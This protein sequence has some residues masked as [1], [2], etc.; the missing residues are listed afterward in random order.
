MNKPVT[1]LF[2][3]S[4][5]LLFAG[6]AKQ[7]A[8]DERPSYNPYV[9]S[10]TSG[11]VSRFSPVYLILSEDIPVD[12]LDPGTLADRLRIKPAAKGEFFFEDSHTLGFRPAGSLEQGTEYR[13]T[14]DLSHW[15]DADAKHARF[16][17]A[18]STYPLTLRVEGEALSEN[19]EEGYDLAYTLFTPD[20][21]TPE[22][23]EALVRASEDVSMEWQHQ[24]GERK[25]LLTLRRLPARKEA[26]SLKLSTVRANAG[27][28]TLTE[29]LIPSVDDF[30]VAGVHF[31]E[32]P[33]RYVEVVFSKKL[34]DAQ[35][36][37]GLAFLRDNQNELL[38]V[39]GN[40]L[41]LYPDQALEGSRKIFLSGNIRSKKG[42]TL[43]DDQEKTVEIIRSLPAIR[44]TG[45]G[46]ILPQSGELSLPFQAIY[47]RGVIVRIIKIFEDNIGQFMQYNTMEGSSYLT[48]T[49]RPVARKTIFFDGEEAGF[50]SWK[51][52]AIRLDELIN[53]EPGAIYRVE[54]DFNRELSAYPCDDAPPRRTRGE[55]EADDAAKLAEETAGYD[56]GYYYYAGT[57]YDY[58]EDYERGKD[59]CSNNYYYGKVQA[60]NIL[61]TN[62]GLMAF[63]D[64]NDVFTVA[65]HNLLTTLPEKNVE[66]TLYNYQ[67]RVVGSGQ[68]DENGQ[69]TV[70]AKGK[71]Y[72]LIASQGRQRAYL[73]LYSGAERSLSAF[74][75]SGETVQKGIKG[76]I[77]GDRGVW[78]PGDTL[79]LGF[80]L[81]D[82]QKS[83]PDNHPVTMELMNPLGQ[84]YLRKTLT[85]G[86]LGVYAFDMPTESNA[87]T[88]AWQARVEVGGA[89][90]S[91]RLR[92]ETV[93]PN[94]LKIALSLP[95]KP[96]L[97]NE[98]AL[99]PLHTEWL[100]GSAAR[101][102]KYQIEG[103]FEAEK[104]EFPTFKDYIFDDPSKTYQMETG[105]LIAGVTDAEGNADVQMRF[106]NGL[107]APGLLTARLTTR[108][109]EPSGDFSIDGAGLR[110]SPYASYVG[111]L[112]PQKGRTQLDTGK[113][114]TFKV[115]TVDYLGAPQPAELEVDVF[116]IGYYW[117]WESS[118]ENLGN[119]ISNSY[120]KL[121][122]HKELK[123]GAGGQASFTLKMESDD[124]GA[125]FIRV[126]DRK[127]QH[128][129]GVTGYFDW[130]GYHRNFSETNAL[131]QLNIRTDKTEYTPGET[132]LLTFPS[133]EG[134][135][136]VAAIANGDRMLT[137]SEHLC[138]AGETTISLEVTPDMQPNAYIY[139]SLLQPYGTASNDLPIRMYG[140][141][142]V[143]VT[144]PESRLNPTLD[145]PGEIK[146][147][148]TYR[149]TVSE[150]NGQAMAYTLAVVDEGL[151][152]LTR[153][154]TPDPWKAF[155]AR[156]ALGVSLW[157][158]YNNVLGAYGGR[159]EQL[160]SIGG[161]DA[162]NRAPKAIV[163]RFKPVV[164]FEGPFL[165][166]KGEKKR[167]TF[168]MPAYSGRVR[169]MLVAGNGQAYGHA[170]KSVPVRKPVM[171]LGTL[172]RVIGAGEEM[173]VPATVFATEDAVG[174]VSVSI[175]CSNNM[176]ILGKASQELHFSKKD[177]RQALFRIRVKDSP[178][179]GKVT[180]VATAK[181]ETSTYETDIEIRS[182]SR[183][184]TQVTASILEAGKTGKHSL[185]LPGMDGTNSLV[186]EVSATPPIN[187]GARLDYLLGYPHGCIEQ[188]TSKAFPQLYLK[189]VASLS[190]RQAKEAEEAVK[191]TLRLYR[192]YRLNGGFSYWPNGNSINEWGSIYATHFLLEAEAK[193]FLVTASLKN[194]ALAGLRT[195]ARAWKPSSSGSGNSWEI[196]MQAYRLYV[197]SMG[198]TPEMG[199]MNRLKEEKNFRGTG[200]WLL[201]AAY[202]KAGRR[203]VANEMIEK[204]SS[205]FDTY[206]GDYYTYG[207]SLRDQGIS[208]QT[209]CLL[210]RN[211]EATETARKI[212]ETLSS[213]IWLSTQETAFALLGVSDYMSRFQTGETPAFSYTIG[214]KTQTI[215]TDKAIWSETL[216][217]AAGETADLELKNT[218]KASLFVRLIARGTPRQDEVEAYAHNV[219]LNVRYT[220]AGGQPVDVSRLEQGTNLV[221]LV[222]VRNTSL[223]TLQNLAVTQVFPSG[224]EILNT[225]YL[226]GAESASS[227]AIPQGVSSRDIRDDRIYSYI[228]YLEPGRE[229][230]LRTNLTAVY[231]G[232]FHLPPVYCESMYD[233][234]TQANTEGQYVEVEQ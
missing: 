149:I 138:R 62:L 88:G 173:L 208:L 162:L 55:I 125:Y 33:E 64:R 157:D 129:A 188:I 187:L 34:D 144:S 35:N 29:T 167:H 128:T 40:K 86:E 232:R 161:G 153:F 74:D 120:F 41:R 26:Y 10:F 200:V 214:G 115:A 206:A 135:R 123:T 19:D 57:E 81:N 217:E 185:R 180:L 71:P 226:D 77:Y 2:F 198:G 140:V 4:T 39:D 199:A 116:F 98:Q 45:E 143:T 141:T 22:T 42:K 16:S 165:L 9:K 178:G 193:G 52:Y 60:K 24:T 197:L 195:L 169:V 176:E 11:T 224:W 69:L 220:D 97:R 30:S 78:R 151:L 110:Y 53:P 192:A 3:L 90:F 67:R 216:P 181:G 91:K 233:N 95:A 186:L 37:Q 105:K 68:T 171:L 6:C 112:S 18:F 89:S 61:A 207:S 130:P 94:R 102:L 228:D 134:S 182:V 109:Y 230:T 111:I 113:E 76:F 51:T 213:D 47:L 25:H 137:L 146:P 222:T 92:I 205:L 58:Y 155:N 114:Y 174:T 136:A 46:T 219:S 83:L 147:E 183:P 154:D 117:W 152:D 17:F 202:A 27:E 164:R 14:A 28:E 84:S 142:P 139:V 104:T 50:T 150:Q 31:T 190:S 87:P 96:L 100:Q 12:R 127:S 166:K 209:L 133:T 172:P 72:Y 229:V 36:L 21:E 93:K 225:R 49:G 159:I 108:V 56:S 32:E 196:R 121:K 66:V 211:T 148:S 101:H 63:G 106:D 122:Q 8:V 38:T 170:E 221:A 234:L 145:L 191:E 79:H 194:D 73:H 1:F 179:A 212:A 177:D 168:D 20:R 215:K 54:L 85:H 48:A 15:F 223:S 189:D 201:A 103:T 210:K 82:R 126:K 59:P 204:A 118:D 218:G 75:V 23:V 124:W 156:E 175:A 107:S 158:V 44:F 160:F 13:I 203:D 132:L 7:A 184:V 99:I 70:A 131:T 227:T 65:V 119:Y 5:L 43:G 231:A 80:M 163:N